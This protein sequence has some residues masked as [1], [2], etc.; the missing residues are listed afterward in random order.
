MKKWIH[1]AS[2]N[3]KDSKEKRNEEMESIISGYVYQAYDNYADA[4]DLTYDDIVETI[5]RYIDTA[6]YEDNNG[7]EYKVKYNQDYNLEDIYD[8]M[9]KYDWDKYADHGKCPY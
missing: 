8:E 5:I 3:S 2:N 9:R 7:T 6:V 1:A 4:D